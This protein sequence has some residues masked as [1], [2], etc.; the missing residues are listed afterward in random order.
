MEMDYDT[1]LRPI[2]PKV[3]HKLFD[4]MQSALWGLSGN[5]QPRIRR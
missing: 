3:P 2:S 1:Y 4:W 5:Q